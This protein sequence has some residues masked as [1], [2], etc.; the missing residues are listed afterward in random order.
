[1]TL[2]GNLRFRGMS[3]YLA[4]GSLHTVGLLFTPDPHFTLRDFTADGTVRIDPRRIETSGRTPGRYG[5]G[6]AD[7]HGPGAAN[8]FP[9]SGRIETRDA[10][11]KDAGRQ[12]HSPGDA[13]RLFRRDKRR[14]PD[15]RASTWTGDVTGFDTR[16]M[17]RVYN[18]QSVP[19]DGAASGPM[20]SDRDAAAHPARCVCL[21]AW[22]LHPPAPALPCM[23]RSTPLT[24]A[25]LRLWIWQRSFLAL[26]GTRLDFSGVLGRQLRVRADSRNLDDVLPAFAIQ[27]LPVKLQNGE[28]VF[29]GSVTGKL[30][31][32]RYRGPWP[33]HQRGLVGKVHSMRS[34]GDVDLNSAR[35]SR[36][37]TAPCSTARCT[38]KARDR[39]PCAIGRLRTPVRY[40]SRAPSATHP[41]WI[42]WRSRISSRFP[43]TGTISA[44]GKITGTFGAPRIDVSVTA[45]NGTLDGEPFDRFTGTLN[46]AGPTVDM[47]NAQL[48]P[49]GKQVTLAAN[50]QHQPD[51]FGKGQLRFQVDSN[52]MPLARFQLVSKDYP[53]IAGTAELHANGVA[54]F[55][56]AKPGQPGFHV[57]ALNGTLNGRGLRI[58]DQALRDATLTAT[59]KG[60]E[61]AA[62]LDSELAGSVIEGDGKWTLA[63]DYPVRGAD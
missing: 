41:P 26:P 51:D 48:A 45:T 6:N 8:A 58:N 61:L 30:D 16:E 55:A 13:E 56:P 31:D 50:Y 34:S 46:Y 35:T 44:D 62:H 14:S 32:P 15:S 18:G 10:A 22:R 11:R 33:R 43:C 5:H 40:R 17:L 24:M 21:P 23:A 63:D 2:A 9:V 27:S 57:V 12:R 19:W 28:A 20:R 29:D 53:G 47:G 25:S 3:D 59:T 54:D 60:S 36:C 42:C 38:R 52:A 4:T 37:T 49:S 39:W 7:R 1:M